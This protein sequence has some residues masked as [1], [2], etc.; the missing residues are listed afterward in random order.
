M[1]VSFAV[2]STPKVAAAMLAFACVVAI[3]SSGAQP[4]FKTQDEK[5]RDLIDGI[6]SEQAR[7]GPNS[8]AL[9]EPLTDL[10]LRY[11]D[12]GERALAIATIQRAIEVIH[13]SRG[14]FTLDQ[15]S[16]MQRLVG[17][18]QARGNS[19]VAWAY[20]Q[21]LLALA[22]RN[23]F[24]RRANQIYIAA[25]DRRVKFLE[26]YIDGEHPPEIVLGCY[27]TEPAF[28]SCHAGSR[29]TV[30]DNVSADAARLYAAGG[31]GR[32]A[33]QVWGQISEYRARASRLE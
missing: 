18:E 33:Q 12:A 1:V 7:E 31:D 28:P 17:L 22:R 30:I 9:I 13:V 8:P 3:A 11:E 27:Y 32:Q 10:S 24:D 6:R 21:K 2:R 19:K 14:L 26:R 4:L 15:A 16:L 29:D 25:A 5:Q 20:E 23:P